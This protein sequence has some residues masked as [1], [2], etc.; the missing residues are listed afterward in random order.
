MRYLLDT[1]VVIWYFEGSEKIRT[2]VRDLLTD[3]ENEVY[4]SDISVLEVVV[5]YM[6]GKLPLSSPPSQLLPS[7]AEEHALATLPIFQESIFRLE[8]LPLLHRDPFDRL[9]IAQSLEHGLTL[10]TPDPLIRQYKVQTMWK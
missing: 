2:P 1:C 4:M 6:L 8:S 9:L 5:K 10:V 7:L 3:P